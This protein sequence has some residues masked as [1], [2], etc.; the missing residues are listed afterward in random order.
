MCSSK[1]T[2]GRQ[3]SLSFAVSKAAGTL[4]PLIAVWPSVVGPPSTSVHAELDGSCAR[5]HPMANNHNK[6]LISRD[7]TLL[8][9][10][11]VAQ[12][13]FLCL[14]YGM[15]S[16]SGTA[17]ENSPSTLCRG[18]CGMFQSHDCKSELI[19]MMTTGISI[20]LIISD[21]VHKSDSC[22]LFL[23]PVLCTALHIVIK[24]CL[25]HHS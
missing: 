10:W 11:A 15:A 17:Q 18:K 22:Q 16:H 25:L 19:T 7:I 13:L 3:Y 1:D 6:R 23:L 4:F 20:N 21:I 2:Q 5:V 8:V 24:V 12:N 14:S 9:F